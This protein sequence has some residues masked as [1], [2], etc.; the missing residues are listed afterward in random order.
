M[1]KDIP[2]LPEQWIGK[3]YITYYIGS[4]LSFGR[5]R[6]WDYDAS[7]QN[8]ILVGVEEVTIPLNEMLDIRE[9]AVTSLRATKQKIQAEAFQRAEKVEQR[10]QS[11]LMIE[12][13]EKDLD[14]EI[15]F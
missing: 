2:S 3:I 5:L 8:D 6:I 7:D 1:S 10:I 4:M 15:P 12:H 13:V 9:A 14:D 11:L